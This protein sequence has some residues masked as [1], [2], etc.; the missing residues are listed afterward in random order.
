MVWFLGSVAWD[1]ALAKDGTSWL[2][3]GASGIPGLLKTSYCFPDQQEA[4]SKKKKNLNKIVH[5][6][7]TE[8]GTKS[9]MLKSNI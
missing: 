7:P 1:G 3:S 8:E 6:H 9:A 5:Y 4:T 2:P